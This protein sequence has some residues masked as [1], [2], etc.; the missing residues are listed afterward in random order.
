MFENNSKVPR[1]FVYMLLILALI[2][3]VC[4]FF[5]VAAVSN[6]YFVSLII[7]V[8]LLIMDKHYGTLLTNY[9]L[10]FFLF[11]IINMVAVIAIIYYEFTKHSMILNIFL[12]TLVII[13]LFLLVLDVVFVKNKNITKNECS[14]VGA[15][16]IGSMIC[17]LTYFFNVSE[18]WYAIDAMLFEIANIVLKIYFNSNKFEKLSEKKMSADEKQVESVENRI[19]S[20][21]ENEG[22]VD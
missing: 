20:A 16:K 9:K 14:L 6:I 8:V 19:R 15:V 22:E 11:D 3:F 4:M 17:I 2:M 21:G 1:F 7:C 12:V 5:S 18:L 10:T 13:E